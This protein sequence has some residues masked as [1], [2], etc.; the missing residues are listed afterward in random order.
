MDNKIAVK[1]LIEQYPD[2]LTIGAPIVVDRNFYDLLGFPL[3]IT[4]QP[5][6]SQDKL[7]QVHAAMKNVLTHM[8]CDEHTRK[9]NLFALEVIWRVLG[10]PEK[11]A[12]YDEELTCLQ[13]TL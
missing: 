12:K 5:K 13:K 6:I 3:G 2:V 9:L 11:R 4:V 7:K 8:V 10:D 1:K